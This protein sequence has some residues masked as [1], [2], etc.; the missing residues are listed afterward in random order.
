[1]VQVIDSCTAAIDWLSTGLEKNRASPS[2]LD[3][4]LYLCA[5]CCLLHFYRS[6]VSA[7]PP[8]IFLNVF[9][10]LCLLYFIPQLVRGDHRAK[11]SFEP[12]LL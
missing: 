4:P 3:P 9:V 7:E 12:D 6:S 8:D 11:Q 10:F 5:R 2:H 1:M